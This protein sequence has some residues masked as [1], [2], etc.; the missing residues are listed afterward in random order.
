MEKSCVM[1]H[2]TDKEHKEY[3]KACF[4]SEVQHAERAVCGLDTGVNWWLDENN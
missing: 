1:M 3:D 2:Q 4:T